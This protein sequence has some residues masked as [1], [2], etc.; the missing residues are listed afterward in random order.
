MY[1]RAMNNMI[2]Q[3]TKRQPNG[4]DMY[5]LSL[6]DSAAY[7]SHLILGRHVGGACLEMQPP[8]SRIAKNKN[9][10]NSPS[11]STLCSE[12]KPCPAFPSKGIP[13]T[14]SST[15]PIEFLWFC[16]PPHKDVPSRR[17]GPPPPFSI[18]AIICPPRFHKRCQVSRHRSSEKNQ[19]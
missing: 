15:S 10:F 12:S 1:I 7:Q 19:L 8:D 3:K 4:K 16:F 6:S 2:K 17:K 13:Y 9:F 11:L 14:H 5:V 18:A